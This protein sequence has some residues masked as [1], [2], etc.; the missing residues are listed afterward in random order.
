MGEAH[1][2]SLLFEVVLQPLGLLLLVGRDTRLHQLVAQVVQRLEELRPVSL[3][4]I[5]DVARL[6]GLQLELGFAA[7]RRRD[8]VCHAFDIDL[9]AEVRLLAAIVLR[10]KHSKYKIQQPSRHFS[11]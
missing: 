5:V 7:G 9:S 11:Q 6:P 2:G 1:A 4:A 10:L 3:L 8:C